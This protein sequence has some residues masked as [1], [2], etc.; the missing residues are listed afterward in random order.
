[1]DYCLWCFCC[2]NCFLDL[3]KEEKKNTVVP[4]LNIE[5]IHQYVPFEDFTEV[6]G[7]NVYWEA[8]KLKRKL[9]GS[10]REK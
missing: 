2:C 8:I 5:E 6:V 9:V 4:E 7:D 10:C 1:M 3:K